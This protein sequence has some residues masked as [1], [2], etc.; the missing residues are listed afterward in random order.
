MDT[1]PQKK[2][3]K[4]I[5]NNAKIAEFKYPKEDGYR[6]VWIFDHSSCHGAYSDDKVQKLVFS[7][8]LP[9][10][11]IQVLK[12]KGK[13]WEGMKLEEMRAEIATHTDFK[14]D[15]DRIFS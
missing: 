7:I 10:G 5:K 15:E 12:E 9:K 3:I 1:G 2:F 11:L 8:G 6:V 14:E 13:Y 4:Q